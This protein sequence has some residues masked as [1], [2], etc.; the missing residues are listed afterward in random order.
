MLTLNLFTSLLGA[1]LATSIVWLVRRGHLHASSALFWLATALATL[2][3]GLWP[4][5]INRL[6]ELTGIAYPPAL[7]LL[8]GLAALLIK[9]LHNDV[10]N[11]RLERDVR[12]LNQRIAMIELAG[13]GSAN[14]SATCPHA[15]PNT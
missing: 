13:L 11:T 9:S 15:D 2:V 4:G 10:Q 14:S 3:L 6:A 1:G 8:C 7:L 5:M 12:R